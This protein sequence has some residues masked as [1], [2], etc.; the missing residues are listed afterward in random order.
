MTA[1]ILVVCTGNVCRS[2]LIERLLRLRL[3]RVGV[4][5]DQVVVESAGVQ[6]MVGH[7]MTDHAVAELQGLGGDPA[8]SSGR[9]LSAV[10]VEAAD[11][12]LTATRAH[13]ARVVTLVP[14]ALPRTFTLRELA[15]LIMDADLSDL[16]ADPGER[17]RRLAQVA[18][19]RRGLLEPVPDGH[20]DVDDPM[21]R[22]RAEYAATTAQV[23]PAAD[24]VVS[25]IRG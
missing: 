16:P 12:V 20:D 14:R 9:Q 25:A 24:V 5:P 17:V 15:R 1:R 2:P 19:S 10:D 22:P 23:V 8:G 7:P 11:L 3:A 18:R 6:A 13:R 21:G 4:G